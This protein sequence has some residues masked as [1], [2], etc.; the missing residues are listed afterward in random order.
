M[1]KETK[2]TLN[3][4]NQKVEMK[5]V[6]NSDMQWKFKHICHSLKFNK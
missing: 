4:F 6:H 2:Q 1:R 5:R 3:H